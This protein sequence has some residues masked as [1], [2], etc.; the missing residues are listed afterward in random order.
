M[1]IPQIPLPETIQQYITAEVEAHTSSNRS[2]KLI[3]T[4]KARKTEALTRAYH[5]LTAKTNDSDIIA[6]TGVSWV[7]LRK[8][9]ELTEEISEM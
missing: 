3:R 7:Q 9:K 6:V 2:V 4:Q 5:H 1:E 8:L